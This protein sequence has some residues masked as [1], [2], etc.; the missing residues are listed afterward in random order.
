MRRLLLA[1]VVGLALS[2]AL[3]AARS[4]QPDAAAAAAPV[5]PRIVGTPIVRF[6]KL[7]RKQAGGK[8]NKYVIGGIVRF[9]RPLPRTDGVVVAP[10]LRVGQRIVSTFGGNPA[11][12]V[13]KTARQCFNV[14][15]IQ[16][17]PTHTPRRHAR[18]VVGVSH[19]RRIQ[20]IK[21]VTLHPF[22]FGGDPLPDARRM[23]CLR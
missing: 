19:E 21:H 10:K 20:S 5:Q 15:M 23:G 13:G 8:P 17:E 11:G 18:W 4:G 9:D 3:I 16:P 22:R 6:L 12:H 14:E 2:G 1:A 7:S